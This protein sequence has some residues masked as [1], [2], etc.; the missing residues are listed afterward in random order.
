MLKP[1]LAM[2]N[3]MLVLFLIIA[4][5]FALRKLNIL[6]ETAGKTMA[7][8]E[9]WVFCPALSFLSMVRYCTPET[10]ATHA[11]NLLL[12][13]F[14][15]LIAI[16]M[17]I[18]LAKLFVKEKCAERGIFCYAL[19][20]A[21]SGYMGDPLILSLLGEEALAYYK[22][23]CVPVTIGILTWGVSMLIPKGEKKGDTLKAIFNPPMVALFLGIF[24]GLLGF[25]KVMPEFLGSTLEGLMSCM[26][27]V[28]M[29]LAGFTIAGYKTREIVGDKK[30]YISSVLRM[31][32]LPAILIGALFGAKELV[33]LAFDLNIDNTVLYLAFFAYATPLGM[34][35]IVYP[36]AYDGNPKTG[37]SMAL[38]SHTL[39]VIVI[40][41][42]YSLMT[43]FFGTV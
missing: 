11:T 30:V 42:T 29:L 40:P 1:F 39:A 20:F 8:L 4:I 31:T 35:T 18:L 13:L 17:G 38:I 2:L 37:A 5:G 10:L 36:E 12:S 21:N 27:P 22:L 33:N 16:P 32:L 25:G 19:V 34:N 28:A 7:K 6:P 24:A 23:F 41:L 14:V 3:P 9:T 26:G 43:V 15:I